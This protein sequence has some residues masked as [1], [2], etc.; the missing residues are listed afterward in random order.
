MVSIDSIK[1]QIQTTYRELIKSRRLTPRYGQRQMIAQITNELSKSENSESNAPIC[2]IEAGTGTGKTLAY[3]ISSIPL[4][5][6]YGHKVIIST[7]TIALQEQVVLKD[8]PEI[9]SS[10]EMSFTYAIAKGRRRYLCLSKLHMLLSGQDS[11][12]ALADFQDSNISD[13]LSSESELYESMLSKLKSG[14][15]HGDR[16]DWDSPLADKVWMPLTADRFQ[17]TGQK[18]NYFRDCSFYK[19]RDA[20]DKVDC[21]VSNHDLVL[22]DLVMGGG[23]ILP[24]PEKCF[25]IFDEAHHLSLI[26]I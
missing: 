10:S 8:I 7:A 14:S 9:L 11:L 16:D 20:L 19:A 2:V 24:E 25:Y 23:A 17:C 3:L 13:Y 1:E 18:C 12:M 15:W 6:N 26:H 22:T 4:A 21:I 5:K